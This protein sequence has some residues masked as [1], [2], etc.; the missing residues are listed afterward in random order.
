MEMIIILAI[1]IVVMEFGVEAI[2][3][4]FD[5]MPVW[6]KI[7]GVCIPVINLLAMANLILG[8]NATIFV[9][10]GIECVAFVDY[11]FTILICSLG[12]TTWHEFK[13]KIKEVATK[14]GD[15]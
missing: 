12:T 11:L 3:K 14:E 8:T 1:A 7:K 4:V 5:T 2:K 10:L 13:K 15:E 9:A 6:E